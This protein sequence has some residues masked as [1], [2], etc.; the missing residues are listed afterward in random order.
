[1]T[2]TIG[3]QH[4]ELL[5]RVELFAGLNRM[6]L[7]QLAAHMTAM[8][9]EAGAGL[10]EQGDEADCLYVLSEGTLVAFVSGGAP[11][12][13]TQLGGIAPGDSIGEMGLITGEPRSATVQ[14]LS[15][16]EVLQFQRESFLDLVQAQPSVG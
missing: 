7:S 8:S 4:A 12:S 10:F 5:G 2:D 6:A 1:M 3:T 13:K 9:L 14:A 16:A 15:A 11:G